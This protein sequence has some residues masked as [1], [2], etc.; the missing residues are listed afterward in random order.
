[1]V[2]NAGSK[3]TYDSAALAR[4]E[5]VVSLTGEAFFDVKASA[6][7]PFV[8]KTG[9]VDV[10]VLGTTFNLKAYPNDRRVETYLISGKVEV[11]YKTKGEEA[12]IRLRPLERVVIDLPEADKAPAA[13]VKPIPV[14]VAQPNSGAGAAEAPNQRSPPGCKGASNSRTSPS[15]NSSTSW[16]GGMM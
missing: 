15:H 2:L 4:G 9:K 14:A 6:E 3:L 8:I 10:R 13:I 1:M 5:R 12:Q 7:H 16:K 11:A